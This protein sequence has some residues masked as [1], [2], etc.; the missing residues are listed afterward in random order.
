MKCEYCENELPTNK[1]DICPF[2]GA[3]FNADAGADKAHKVESESIDVTC[4]HCRSIYEISPEEWGRSRNC[5]VCHKQFPLVYAEISSS[6]LEHIYFARVLQEVKAWRKKGLLT[7]IESGDISLKSG[8]ILYC[9]LWNVTLSESRGV[10]RTISERTSRR[11]YSHNY[12]YMAERVRRTGERYRYDGH[13]ETN[14]DYEYKELDCGVLCL[15]SYRVF[16]IG[17]Q[18]QRYVDLRRI[19][20]FVP[21]YGRGEGEIR[22]SEEGKQKIMRFTSD[23]GFCKFSLALKALRDP[24]FKRFL[25]NESDE[26]VCARFI[27]LDY[28][29][30]LRPQAPKKLPAPRPSAPPQKEVADS[31]EIT[32]PPVVKTILIAGGTISA[33]LFLSALLANFLGI[34]FIWGIVIVLVIL[35]PIVC[36]IL[37][38]GDKYLYHG[39]VYVDVSEMGLFRCSIASFMAGLRGEGVMTALEKSWMIKDGAER[40]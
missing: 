32:I 22:I 2:C 3:S 12:D 4:P 5:E 10:R 23:D 25:L 27:K 13:S 15:T 26:T 1:T 16:F 39:M 29:A 17:S 8:E 36:G 6:Q 30:N 21:H 18:M 33:L 14:T 24:S 9:K 38:S 28:F 11:D 37:G 20:S 35:G 31:N 19:V 7:A 34:K 40:L